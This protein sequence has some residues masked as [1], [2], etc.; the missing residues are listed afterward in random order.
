MHSAYSKPLSVRSNQ[1]QDFQSGCKKWLER[2]KLL[3]QERSFDLNPSVLTKINQKI[4]RERSIFFTI[5]GK[6]VLAVRAIS[7]H[8]SAHRAPYNR[9]LTITYRPRLDLARPGESAITHS[10]H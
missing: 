8:S 2:R 3:I 1:K 5:N 7:E 4:D 6:G 9:L 10:S